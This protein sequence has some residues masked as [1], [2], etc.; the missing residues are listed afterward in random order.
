MADLFEVLALMAAPASLF[1]AFRYLNLRDARTPL[2]KPV[3]KDD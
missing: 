1:L 2:P 3:G